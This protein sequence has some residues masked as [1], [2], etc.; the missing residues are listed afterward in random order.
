[1][2]RK[3]LITA[4]LAGTLLCSSFANAGGILVFDATAQ[5]ENVKQWTKEA[6]QWMDT[7]KHYRSQL[8]AY[9]SQLATATGIRDVQL[10]LNQA[11]SLTSDLKNLQKNGV[12]LNDL[13]SNPTGQM[14][15]T[16]N[17]LYNKYSMFDSCETSAS[18]QGDMIA[19]NCKQMVL[20]K[21]VA[22]EETTQT[23]KKINETLSDISSLAGRVELSKDAKESQ[24]LANAINT[25]SVQLSALSAQWEMSVKQSELRDKMFIAQQKK[26]YQQQQHN[27]PVADLNNL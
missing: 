10:F 5:V 1:M 6:N 11:K 25:K 3:N 27:A 18:I 12:S 14:N 17:S 16:L 15:G 22:I 26:A 19:R 20:N 23:Q 9:K 7:V 4:C 2:K 24:D 8:D 13:L 21:A